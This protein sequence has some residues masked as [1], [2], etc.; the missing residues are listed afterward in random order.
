MNSH[1]NTASPLA[2]Q[3]ATAGFRFTPM[4]TQFTKGAAA[5]GG[6]VSRAAGVDGRVHSAGDPP[7]ERRLAAGDGH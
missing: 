2:R 1:V 3:P 6:C 7:A 5:D 4:A